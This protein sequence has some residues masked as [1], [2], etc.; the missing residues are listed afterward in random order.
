MDQGVCR[1]KPQ[2]AL[3]GTRAADKPVEERVRRPS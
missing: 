1:G 2:G 3:D